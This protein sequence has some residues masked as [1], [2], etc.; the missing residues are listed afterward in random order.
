MSKPYDP[1]TS[2]GNAFFDLPRTKRSKPA[3]D[4]KAVMSTKTTDREYLGDSVYVETETQ[5]VKLTTNNGY[6]DDPRNVIYMEPSVLE[7]LLRWLRASGWLKTK[8]TENP[9]YDL[10]PEE[11]ET[12]YLP[13]GKTEEEELSEDLERLA[14]EE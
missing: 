11:G 14:E 6:P 10:S 7:N 1:I 4:E 8:G 2:P 5:M 9:R 3:T 12:H 13:R